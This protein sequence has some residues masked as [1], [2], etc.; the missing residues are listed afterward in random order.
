MVGEVGLGRGKERILYILKKEWRKFQL[1]GE[2]IGVRSFEESLIVFCD[3]KDLYTISYHA[4]LKSSVLQ[5]Q[6]PIIKP[7]SLSF[8]SRLSISHFLLTSQ[9]YE[10][11]HGNK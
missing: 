9:T 5:T 6:H 1:L 7:N 11:H 4:L 3:I 8:L 2:E 10:L